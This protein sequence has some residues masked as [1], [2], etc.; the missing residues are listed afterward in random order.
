MKKQK[1]WNDL[2][3]ILSSEMPKCPREMGIE[4]EIREVLAVEKMSLLPYGRELADYLI[5]KSLNNKDYINAS[6]SYAGGSKMHRISL[7]G[8]LKEDDIRLT[9]QLSYK[10][11]TKI[12]EGHLAFYAYSSNNNCFNLP[13]NPEQRMFSMWDA[14]TAFGGKE[15]KLETIEK[16]LW[17]YKDILGQLRKTNK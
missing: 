12:T 10:D 13:A 5:L 17:L 14:T 15:E 3:E 6:Y 2:I 1:T 7:R 9:L 8:L 11:Y 4:N 16:I